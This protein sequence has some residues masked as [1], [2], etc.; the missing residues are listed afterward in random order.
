[1]ILIDKEIREFVND[2][3]LIGNYNEERLNSISYDVIIDKFIFD[4]IELDKDEYLLSV[5]D[6]V[7][8]KTVESLNMRKDLCCRVI[9]KNSLMRKGL[10][11]DGPMYQPGH[12]T[13][14]FLRVK[15]ISNHDIVLNKG[16]AI[17]QLVFLK[18]DDIPDKTYDMQSDA[19]Y[20]GEDKFR[21]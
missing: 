13:N 9:E 10:K 11:V 12:K 4:D 14:V 2:D 21:I 18:L 17:A 3:G 1:M 5:K 7:Y 6:Y 15:N 19:K 16:M 20:N 8:I